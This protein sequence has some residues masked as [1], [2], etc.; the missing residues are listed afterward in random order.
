MY[1]TGNASQQS[2]RTMLN[3]TDSFSGILLSFVWSLLSEATTRV[4]LFKLE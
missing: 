1:Q 2:I 4:F 3:V